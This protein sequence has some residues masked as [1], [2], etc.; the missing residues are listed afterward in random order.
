MSDL[1]NESKEFPHILFGGSGSFHSTEEGKVWI[2]L[3]INLC[4]WLHDMYEV[5]SKTPDEKFRYIEQQINDCHALFPTKFTLMFSDPNFSPNDQHPLLLCRQEEH[6]TLILVFRA[7]VL[8]ESIHDVFTD[9]SIY[10]NYQTHLGSGHSGFV[11]RV[12]TAPLLAVTN[13]LRHGWKI[14]ITGHSLGGAVSQLFTAQIISKLV[15]TGI[16]PEMVSLRC[17]TFRYTS[18][19]RSSFLE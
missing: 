9:A 2:R 13:W 6:K 12:E 3:L 5:D 17:V 10:T 8:S 4:W 7:T 15:E 18:M 16:S 14:I 1:I 19:C 11:Q